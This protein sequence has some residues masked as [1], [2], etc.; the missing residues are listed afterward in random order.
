[1]LAVSSY[2]TTPTHVLAVV[3][4]MYT[5]CVCIRDVQG[6]MHLVIAYTCMIA[7]YYV[8]L[9]RVDEEM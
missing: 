6:A 1:M 3:L 7:N 8:L 5:Y 4:S 9:R 2:N